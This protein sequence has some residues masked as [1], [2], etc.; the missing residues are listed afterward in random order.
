MNSLE[1]RVLDRVIAVVDDK[2]L[3]LSDLDSLEAKIKK[4]PELKNIFGIKDADR[5]SL[6]QH[7]INEKV[8]SV[9]LD[10]V[11]SAVST[12]DVETQIE[13]IAK[14]NNASKEQ[15][16]E[17]LRG[18]GLNIDL[19]KKIVKKQ[20]ER[21]KVFDQYV[22]KTAAPISDSELKQK[23][24]SSASSELQLEL[25]SL[26]SSA[27]NKNK[28]QKAIETFNT[29]KESSALAGLNKTDLGWVAPKQLDK[30]FQ[31]KLQSANANTAYG[32]IEKNGQVFLALVRGSRKGSD[33]QFEANKE[34]IR[35]QVLAEDYELRFKH[36]LKK[37][38]NELEVII[39]KS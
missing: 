23:F 39:N 31:E 28:V 21:K 4:Q 27:S 15:L 30:D 34:N 7:L 2:A 37:Q 8:I 12:E 16:I 36:W 29:S 24:S 26:K 5:D 20:I 14:S 10:K 18:D 9:S 3:L 38:R 11:D 1:A 32:L 25:Y 19:Y 33:D 22:R 13:R 6:F 35:Q 17:S